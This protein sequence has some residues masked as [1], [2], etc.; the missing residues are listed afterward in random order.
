LQIPLADQEQ[1]A[2]SLRQ[3]T[4]SGDLDAV[5]F[6]L[7]KRVALAWEE[8]GYFKT[9]VQ[10]DARV[11]TSSPV[12]QR[13]WVTAHVDAGQQYRLGALT[14]KNNRAVSN[15]RALRN[16]FPIKQGDVFNITKIRESIENLRKVYGELGYINSTFVP[17]MRVDEERQ[18]ISVDIDMDE[19]KPFTISSIDFI[20][21][22]QHALESISKGMYFKRGDVYNSRLASLFMREHAS[23]P[24][25]VPLYSRIRLSRDNELATVGLTFDFRDC[26]VD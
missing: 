26:P 3:R 7:Q 13:I 20:G 18:T 14:F 23:L 19:G 16:L 24:S 12:N 25:N 4:Y 1:V 9:K 10:V 15:V 6:E 22:D 2:S 5:I 8:R 17:D 21:L 11:L